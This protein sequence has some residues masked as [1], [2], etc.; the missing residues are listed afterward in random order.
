MTMENTAVNVS[1]FVT[2]L[3][4]RDGAEY[5]FQPLDSYHTRV[6]Q[7]ILKLDSLIGS[8]TPRAVNYEGWRGDTSIVLA[9]RNTVGIYTIFSDK[10]RISW[11]G[12]TIPPLWGKKGDGRY[13]LGVNNVWQDWLGD[14]EI[15]HLGGKVV[16]SLSDT[17]VSYLN[18]VADR[19][20]SLFD[21]LNNFYTYRDQN[22]E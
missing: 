20:D 18:E 5:L 3:Q 2:P 9:I 14:K 10:E 19:V 1:L 8:L 17:G 6:E 4:I 12:L 21:P 13:S 15:V 11:T 7:T 16:V 22:D